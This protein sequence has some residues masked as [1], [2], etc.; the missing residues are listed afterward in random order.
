[1]ENNYQNEN[2][3]ILISKMSSNMNFSAVFVII[4]GAI[5]AITIVGALVGVPFIFA[6][7]KLREAALAFENYAQTMEPKD[8]TDAFQK[9][10]R[11]FWILKVII[12]VSILLYFIAIAAIFIW[13]LPIIRN[14]SSFNY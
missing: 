9:Q 7:L 8:L 4:Y 2:E 12:I 3:S 6:G 13:F 11:A 1:M 14:A 10:A 5:N